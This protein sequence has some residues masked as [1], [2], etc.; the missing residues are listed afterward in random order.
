MSGSLCILG[1]QTSEFFMRDILYMVY[2][3]CD[4]VSLIHLAHFPSQQLIYILCINCP[5]EV[6]KD[7]ESNIIRCYT[8]VMKEVAIEVT[9]EQ[10]LRV[11]VEENVDSQSVLAWACGRITE[12]YKIT[13]MSSVSCPL[14]YTASIENRVGKI[15]DVSRLDHIHANEYVGV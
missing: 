6:H 2:W 7:R 11:A 12:A 3:L 1:R 13:L 4:A 15:A 9:Q 5:R 8:A 10:L 14:R